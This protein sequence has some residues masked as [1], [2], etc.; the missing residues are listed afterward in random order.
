MKFP[1]SR[2]HHG[3]TPADELKRAEAAREDVEK[4]APEVHRVAALARKIRRDNH[5]GPDI[6]AALEGR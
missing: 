5:L 6:A 3:R 1:R 2:R 4:V